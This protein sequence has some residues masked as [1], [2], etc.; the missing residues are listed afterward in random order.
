M[1]TTTIENVGPQK[2]FYKLRVNCKISS[3]SS[4]QMLEVSSTS[5]EQTLAIS[6]TSSEQTLSI[7]ST[8][9][10]QTLVNFEH[11]RR[12]AVRER[13]ASPSI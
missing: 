11:E 9:S 8:S 5:S 13:A 12:E 4:E 10:E 1:E 7:S 6:S 3:T 2:Y